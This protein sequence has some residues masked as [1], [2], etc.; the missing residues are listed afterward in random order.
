MIGEW[1]AVVWLA[2]SGHARVRIRIFCQGE[3]LTGVSGADSGDAHGRRF[4]LEDAVVAYSLSL[5][6]LRVKTQVPHESG[7]GRTF[8]CRFLLEGVVLE[9]TSCLSIDGDVLAMAMKF[10]GDDVL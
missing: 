6:R 3:N 7:S 8:W 4:L 5:L 2:V 10:P 9:P 1:R